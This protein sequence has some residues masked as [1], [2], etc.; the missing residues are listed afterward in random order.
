MAFLL[1]KI[2]PLTSNSITKRSQFLLH[3]TVQSPQNRGTVITSIC[4][5]LSNGSSWDSLTEEFS[6]VQ[7]TNPLIQKVL[8]Q[9]KEP[10]N[11]KK[12]LSFFHWSAKQM[13]IQHGVSTYCIT[14][15]IL[16]KAK[17]VKDAKALLQSVLENPMNGEG[18]NSVDE[19]SLTGKGGEYEVGN[20]RLF[21][22]LEA[23]LDSYVVVDSVPFVFD[24]FMQTCAKLRMFDNVVSACEL[25]DEHGFGLS[26]I[27]YNTL[28]HVIQKSDKPFLVWDVYEH[29]I[30]K[31]MYPNE[32]TYRILTSAL[33]K[34]GKL[35]RF[36]NVVER[37]HGK[38]CSSPG[39]VVNTCLVF[40]MIS[41]DR[42]EDGLTLLK[43]L[44]QKNM[45]LDTVV[46]SLVTF[47]KLKM[48]DVDGAWEI[49]EGMCKRGFENNCFVITLFIEAYSKEGRIK[50]AIGLMQ[51]IENMKL[52][53]FE[54]TFNHLIEGCSQVGYW[55]ESLEFCRRMI[56]TGL[57]PSVSVFNKTVEMIGEI[58]HIKLADELLT[59]L[60]D[61]GFIPDVN[62]YSLLISGYKKLSNVEGILKLY[63]E[64]VYRALS[65]SAS[66]FCTLIVTLCQHGRV[67]EADEYLLQMKANSLAPQS[68]V[69][70]ALVASHLEKGNNAR[71]H[72][73][74]EEMATRGLKKL[75]HQCSIPMD[76]EP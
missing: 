74:D 14:V 46:L 12:A 15:H 57:V 30:K 65:P 5:S 23:L 72:Q 66:I 75:K 10:T 37:I 67:R 41:E 69:Y 73:L 39:V 43:R 1:R 70:E 36:I 2:Q 68:Y 11:A 29:M 19:A 21:N 38:R 32:V 56:D 26:V 49:Y 28:F 31:R 50:E 55:E 4:N 48:G 7:W 64:M 45:I 71:A 16:V 62:T 9:L 24:L 20:S 54:D 22:V 60:V 76:D 63:H 17:L 52:K 33:S 47:A 61:K 25:L 3:T 13:L 58:G 53:P 35:M 18:I 44:S 6:S 51:E 40:Q 42:I 34:E 27:S 59:V 8:L